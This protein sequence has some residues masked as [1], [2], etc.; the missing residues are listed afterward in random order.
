MTLRKKIFFLFFI[1]PF[2]LFSQEF[3]GSI[4]DKKTNEGLPYV[5]IGVPAKAWG[6]LSDENGNFKFK[7]TSEKDDD[8]IQIS[9]IGYQ[10]ILLKLKELKNQCDSNGIFYLEEM[11]YQLSQ[12]TIT[13]NEYETKI[14]GGKNLENLECIEIPQINDTAYKRMAHEKGLDT[15][16]IGF[17][18]GN[19]IKIKNGQQNFIDKIQFKVCLGI[20]DTAIYRVNIYTKGKTVS[21][22]MTVIGMI[23]EESL[24]NVMKEPIVIKAFGKT[25]VKSI[26]LSSQNIEITDDFIIALECIYASDKK[27]KIGA[28]PSIFGSTDLFVRASV[29]SEW[30]KIPLIDLTFISATVSCKKTP[31]FW[32]RLF[33]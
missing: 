24:I 29:M 18:F 27:M 11:T 2:F 22:H 26:D 33:N 30:I 12:V 25:E 5:N 7:A 17:E 32:Q 16:A 9:L 8:T 31:G 28:D 14:L 19:K 3:K 23:N 1:F 20:K 15:N 10:T 4:K 21:R 13:P 6:F